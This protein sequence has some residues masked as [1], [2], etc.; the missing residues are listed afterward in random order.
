MFVGRKKG[1][2]LTSRATILY[3]RGHSGSL[4]GS[5]LASFWGPF[6]VLSRKSRF[7]GKRAPA[8]MGACFSRVRGVKKNMKNVSGSSVRQEACSKSVLG[9]SRARFGSILGSILDPKIISE[10][11]VRTKFDVQFSKFSRGGSAPPDPPDLRLRAEMP[12][13]NDQAMRARSNGHNS[14]RI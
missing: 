9:G 6:S 1:S 2:I 3:F 10:T 11:P 5:I 4:L 13:A 12:M 7:S 14:A 8:Y